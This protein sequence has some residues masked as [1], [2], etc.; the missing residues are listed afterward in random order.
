MNGSSIKL[1]TLNT[2]GGRS[3][4]P[5]MHFLRNKAEDTDIFCLQEV[6]DTDQTALDA[7]HQKEYVCGPLFKKMSDS[8]P[9][10]KGAFACFKD[11]PHDMSLALFVREK[12]A[13]KTI[14]DFLIYQ[15]TSSQEKG[16]WTLSSRKLQYVTLTNVSGNYTIVNFH[17]L[18]TGGS[19]TDTPERI[20]QSR[21]V[22]KFLDSIDGSKILCGDFNLLPD[23]ESMHILERG[24][25]NLVREAGIV[26][27]RTSLYRHYNN[28]NVP[29]FADYILVSPEIHVQRFEVLP[30]LVSDHSPLLLEFS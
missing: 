14:L 18:W 10:L 4:Y 29:N 24:M 8:L 26:S 19:K 28:P 23:T 7:F 9:D 21:T 5:L 1:I 6:F 25:R 17:G 20:E 16:N 15:Q 22:K 27:T 3:L 11:N 13:T 30:D 12:L 2:W